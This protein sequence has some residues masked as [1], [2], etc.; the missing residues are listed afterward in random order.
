MSPYITVCIYN[1]TYTDVMEQ[2]VRRTR[3]IYCMKNHQHAVKKKQLSAKQ[4]Q[5][6]GDINREP[7]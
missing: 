6:N 4:Q 1:G 7:D 3:L 5:G 2:N